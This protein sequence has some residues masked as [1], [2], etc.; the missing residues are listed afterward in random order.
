MKKLIILLCH[1]NL[2]HSLIH[3]VVHSTK[4]DFSPL[5]YRYWDIK[6]NTRLSYLY[7]D[8][9]Q[10]FIS[11]P[12]LSLF[13][14]SYVP[15][16]TSTLTF[17]RCFRFYIWNF[18]SGHLKLGPK[19]KLLFVFPVNHWCTKLFLP[20]GSSDAPSQ[21]P[22]LQWFFDILDPFSDPESMWLPNA[23]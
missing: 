9:F 6:L 3:Q 23:K 2:I 12:I 8:D 5:L 20:I 19:K 1:W 7:A 13:I 10:A 16:G 14:G 15:S 11:T 22:P 21:D 17:H 18:M 4:A